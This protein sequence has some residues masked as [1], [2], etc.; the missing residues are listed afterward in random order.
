M[1]HY[2]ENTIKKLSFAPT[3]LKVFPMQNVIRKTK[4]NTPIDSF[5][6]VILLNIQLDKN[7]H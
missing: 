1:G 4:N 7:S 6:H 2:Q 5:K 3:P